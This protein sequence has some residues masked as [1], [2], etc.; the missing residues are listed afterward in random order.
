LF[1]FC[2]Q[3]CE[4]DHLGEFSGTVE[5][6]PLKIFYIEFDNLFNT[7]D[8]NRI[9]VVPIECKALTDTTIVWWELCAKSIQCNLVIVVKILQYTNNL[10]NPLNISIGAMNNLMQTFA[11]LI[12]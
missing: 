7:A 11:I 12:V 3:D 9:K 5:F 10:V 4:V 8:N 1:G 2:V 6:V